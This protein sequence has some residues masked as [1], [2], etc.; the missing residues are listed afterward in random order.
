MQVNLDYLD[1]DDDGKIW[2][3]L[4][5]HPIIM[6]LFANAAFVNGEWG[7]VSSRSQIWDY[8]AL[9]TDLDESFTPG[10]L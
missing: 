9:R 1:E 3:G 5:L 8:I 10:A 2:L 7:P 6:A 4:V